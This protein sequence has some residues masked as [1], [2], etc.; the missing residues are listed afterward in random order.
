MSKEALD[1]LPKSEHYR[2][3]L[4]MYKQILL[5]ESSQLPEFQW[6]LKL[7]NRHL[8]YHI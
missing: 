1:A 7:T 2:M 4:C 3:L 6:P 5:Y 8:V